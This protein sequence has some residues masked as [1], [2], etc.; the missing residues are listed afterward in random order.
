MTRYAIDDA[1][2]ALVASWSTGIGDA[3]AVV[4]ELPVRSSTGSSCAGSPP[5]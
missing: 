1:C 3:A 2:N 4:T 5:T